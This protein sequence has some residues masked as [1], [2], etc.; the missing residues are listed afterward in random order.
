ML[1][2]PFIVAVEQRQ[3]LQ[4]L[5]VLVGETPDLASLR[6]LEVDAA[7]MAERPHWA[8]VLGCG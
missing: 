2:Q 3:D 4:A 8:G 6:Q 7:I 1:H 5:M